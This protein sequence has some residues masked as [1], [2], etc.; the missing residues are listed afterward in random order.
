MGISL[1]L[2]HLDAGKIQPAVHKNYVCKRQL[3]LSQSMA[4]S[5]STYLDPDL[6]ACAAQAQHSGTSIVCYACTWEGGE[7]PT[8]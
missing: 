7:H 8:L 2:L 1:N 3:I 6:V 5:H 4:V